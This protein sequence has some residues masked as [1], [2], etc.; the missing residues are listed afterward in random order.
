MANENP[1]EAWAAYMVEVGLR[2]H[3]LRT[4]VGLSQEVL[5][6]RAGLTRNHYQLLEKGKSTPIKA[7]NPQLKV[8][9]SLAE[10]LNVE[11]SD[12]LPKPEGIAV[13]R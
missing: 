12:L 9:A 8:L 4:D 7:A 3:R 13:G 5:A 10:V 11:L 6:N 1:D 2:L